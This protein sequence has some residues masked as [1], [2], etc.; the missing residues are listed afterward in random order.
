MTPKSKAE[1]V[2]NAVVQSVEKL[3][4]E[5][6]YNVAVGVV[7]QALTHFAEEAILDDRMRRTADEIYQLARNSALEEAANVILDWP[8]KHH[9]AISMPLVEA[10]RALKS[11]GE[12]R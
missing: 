6:D 2:A 10:I 9:E 11:G 7:A 12:G 1:D 5:Y 3:I 8:V 4:H